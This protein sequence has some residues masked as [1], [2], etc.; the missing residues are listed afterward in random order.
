[1]RWG[2]GCH[3]ERFTMICCILPWPG[4]VGEKRNGL[5][6]LLIEDITQA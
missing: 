2:T 1:M 5:G 4:M 3:A 6:M